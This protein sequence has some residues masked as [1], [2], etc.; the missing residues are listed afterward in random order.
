MMTFRDLTKIGLAIGMT[1]I[2][3]ALL[4]DATAVDSSSRM[5]KAVEVS[6]AGDRL[7]DANK[8]LAIA[9]EKLATAT[10]ELERLK[11]STEQPVAT[12]VDLT[13]FYRT[14]ASKLDES[15]SFP[16]WSAVPRGTHTFLNVP[17]QIGGNLPL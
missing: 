14:L 2:I 6:T 9:N 3:I 15:D 10:A 5:I 4:V 11:K 16:A 13:D 7:T 17:L 1:C 8:K 12:P